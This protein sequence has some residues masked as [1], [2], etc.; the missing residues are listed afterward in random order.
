LLLRRSYTKNGKRT[1]PQA[2]TQEHRRRKGKKVV[3]APQKKGQGEDPQK[4]P[5]PRL[6]RKK[7]TYRGG[8]TVFRRKKIG[9]IVQKKK[10]A[11]S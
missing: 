11:G 3:L 5:Y 2:T 9:T 1:S 6:F 10:P 7:R 4:T 8:E